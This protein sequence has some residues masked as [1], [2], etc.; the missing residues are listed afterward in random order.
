LTYDTVLY[1][2]KNKVAY[3]TLNRPDQGNALN[4]QM[5]QELNQIWH[6]INEDD[7]VWMAV[8]QGAGKDFCLGEDADEIAEAYRNGT[9]VDRWLKDEAWQRKYAKGLGPV[10]GWPEPTLGLPGKPLM[11]T[12]HGRCH[13]AGMMMVAHA[14]FAIASDDAEFS[15]PEVHQGRVP[16]HE[17][18]SLTRSMLRTPVLRLALMGKHDKWTAARARQLGL[19]FETAPQE[20]LEGR[21]AEIL[22][23][24]VNRSAPLAIRGTRAGWWNTLDL[25]PAMASKVQH[26]YLAEVRTGS[27]DAREG[28][29]AFAE[30]RQAQWKAR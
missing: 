3:V 25:T 5:H 7:D 12:V 1:E 15:L 2:V 16:V 14:D 10:F 13:G 24:V 20:K 8:I 17:I 6:R 27:E 22:D 28:P 29:R 23:T 26:I 18:I 11:A 30:K 9:K 4:E 19:I 21:L